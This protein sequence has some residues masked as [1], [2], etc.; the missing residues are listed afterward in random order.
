MPSVD[1]MQNESLTTYTILE[2]ADETYYVTIPPSCHDIADET[3]EFLI[4]ERKQNLEPP[5][6]SLP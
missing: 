5:K 2:G 6:K 4:P 3:T 1:I